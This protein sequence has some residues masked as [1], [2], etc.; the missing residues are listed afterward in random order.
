MLAG[1]PLVV[2]LANKLLVVGYQVVFS[3][4]RSEKLR[5][6]TNSG[7]SAMLCRLHRADYDKR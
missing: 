6:V 3:F 2:T 4:P 7:G 5:L 1:L